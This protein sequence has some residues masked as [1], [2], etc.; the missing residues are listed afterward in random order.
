MGDRTANHYV[1]AANAFCN[2]CVAERRLEKNLLQAVKRIGKADI[3]TKKNRR[4]LTVDELKG[5]LRI[6]PP[7]WR[8]VYLAAVL[9]GLRE[10]W[11]TTPT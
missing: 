8:I 2:W 9:T 6:A 4:A 3:E 10:L 5:L 7:L 11:G 1:E